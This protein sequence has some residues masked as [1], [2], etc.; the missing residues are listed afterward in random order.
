MITF[1]NNYKHEPSEMEASAKTLNDLISDYNNI[2]EEM[3]SLINEIN[4]SPA[5]KN[6]TMKQAFN[7]TSNGYMKIH[8]NR[9]LNFSFNIAKLKEKAKVAAEFDENYTR[10]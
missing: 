4:S 6:A 10:I 1:A 2:L 7:N 8:N 9:A 5:W 3:Q